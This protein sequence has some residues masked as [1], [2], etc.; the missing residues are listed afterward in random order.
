MNSIRPYTGADEAALLALW[1][2]ALPLDAL[3]TAA[4]RRRVLLDP[5]V[6]PESLLVAESDGQP[7][8]FVLA[9]RR[10]EPF[11]DLGLQPEQAWITAFGVDPAHQRQGLGRALFDAAEGQL[12]AAGVRRVAV[13]PY[14]PGY[15]VPGVDEAAY[16][17]ALAFLAGR[18]YEVVQRPVALDAN[19]VTFDYGPYLERGAR[20][21]AEGLLVAPLAA[22]W[23]PAFLRF[24]ETDLPHDWLRDARDLLAHAPLE[25][26]TIARDGARVIGYC[27]H[28][29]EHFGPFGVSEGYRGRGVGKV[30]LATCLRAMRTRGLHNAWVLWTSDQTAERV[31]GPLGFR[32]TRRFAVLRRE[33]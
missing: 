9:V 5:N 10:R 25:T 19:L 33:L 1:A 20:L 13:A 18:G 31:Y 12:A 2:A 11:G 16:P 14:I 15:F 21:A 7:R 32:Q 29:G 30:L 22:D 3:D 26:I 27:Q 17:A 28:R 23:L 24:A 8:G 6:G 4:F